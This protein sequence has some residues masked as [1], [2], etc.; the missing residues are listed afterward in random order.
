L[1]ILIFK[2]FVIKLWHTVVCNTSYV[3][4]LVYNYNI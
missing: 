3:I 2:Y 1:H 4:T